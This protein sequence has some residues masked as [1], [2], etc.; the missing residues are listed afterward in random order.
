MLDFFNRQHI[1]PV[2]WTGF[3]TNDWYMKM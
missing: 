1:C 3:S 2:R